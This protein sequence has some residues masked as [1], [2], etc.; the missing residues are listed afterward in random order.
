MRAWFFCRLGL[1]AWGG[2]V[3]PGSPGWSCSRLLWEGMLMVRRVVAVG[4]WVLAVGLLGALGAGSVWGALSHP[5][6]GQL[7]PGGGSFGGIALDQG[8]VAVDD[9]NGR[10]Y[11]AD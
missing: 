3:L 10:T 1:G 7:A 9:S 8:S 11:V 2:F 6:A 4:A 5:F